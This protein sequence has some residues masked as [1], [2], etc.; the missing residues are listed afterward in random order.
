MVEAGGAILV[1]DEEF[2]VSWVAEMVPPLLTSR[3]RLTRMGSA[4]R[5]LV[6]ADADEAVANMVL[7][8]AAA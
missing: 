3:E 1:A 5:G 2:T 8:A 7:G 6:R 4:A